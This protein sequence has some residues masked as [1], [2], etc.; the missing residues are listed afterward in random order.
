MYKGMGRFAYF[1][2]FF[3][4]T[5]YPMKM[6]SFHFHR[7]LKKRGGGVERTPSGSATGIPECAYRKECYY[8][9]EIVFIV[10]SPRMCTLKVDNNKENMLILIIWN[11]FTK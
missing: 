4:N 10:N 5:G 7:I 1:I 3:L 8:P 6:K 9:C 11:V 2:L